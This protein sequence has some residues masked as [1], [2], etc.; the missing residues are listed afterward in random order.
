MSMYKSV[1]YIQTAEV[2]WWLRGRGGEEDWMLWCLYLH[3]FRHAHFAVSRDHIFSKTKKRTNVCLACWT[4]T[5]LGYIITELTL[6]GFPFWPRA[7]KCFSYKWWSG[8]VSFWGWDNLDWMN[9]LGFKSRVVRSR[10][11]KA[12]CDVCTGDEGRIPSFNYTLATNEYHG[13]PQGKRKC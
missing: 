13:N 5:R 11:L 7:L 4:L 8:G 3:L 10:R 2:R 1:I 9:V 12:F 6:T